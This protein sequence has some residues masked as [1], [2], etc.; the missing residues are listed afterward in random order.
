MFMTRSFYLQQLLKLALLFVFVVIIVDGKPEQ[1]VFMTSVEIGGDAELHDLASDPFDE[2]SF[3]PAVLSYVDSP[4]C[5]PT[6]SEF[7]ISN[8]FDYDVQ[9]Y[10]V[11]S[12]NTQFHPVM[13]QPQVLPSHHSLSVQLLFLP[14]FVEQSN[15]TLTFSSSVGD[16]QYTVRGSAVKN[17]YLIHPFVGHRL[18]AGVVYEQ[19]IVIYN[20][21]A[22]VLHIR[23]V[24]TTE[25]FM[26]LRGA[27]M[28]GG[29]G[30]DGDDAQFEEQ[31]S[32]GSDSSSAQ[33]AKMWEIEPFTSK[34]VIR[35][36]IS[37]RTTGDYQGYVHVKTNK[38][39]MVIPVELLVIEGGLS[40]IPEIIDFGVIPTPDLSR[41][42]DIYIVN[43]GS[44][45]V[46]IMDVVPVEPDPLLTI[47][48]TGEG[49]PLLVAGEKTLAFRV[50]LQGHTAGLVD[51]TLLVMTNHPNPA[52]ATIETPYRGSIMHGGLGFDNELSYF[53]LPVNN[54]SSVDPLLKNAGEAHLR[55][56]PLTN[57]FNSDISI[58]AVSA[59]S[60]KDMIAVSVDS[61][62][63]E[64]VALDD[65]ADATSHP[66][67]LQFSATRNVIRSN[68]A[69]DEIR[70]VFDAENV[71]DTFLWN[72]GKNPL[73]TL[74]FQC[75][76]EI[77]TNISTH[78]IPL[79]IF[80]G[81]VEVTFYDAA[82]V[83]PANFTDQDINGA[84]PLFSTYKKPGS[85]S[86]KLRKT[87]HP[88][89][90]VG[91]RNSKSAADMGVAVE[92]EDAS[93]SDDGDLLE[94][95]SGAADIN[96]SSPLHNKNVLVADIGTISLHQPKPALLLLGNPHPFDMPVSLLYA[97]INVSLCFVASWKRGDDEEDSD[98]VWPSR[99]GI[100]DTALAAGRHSRSVG[101]INRDYAHY[102]VANTLGL[103]VPNIS[104]EDVPLYGN[105]IRYHKNARTAKKRWN[106]K[107]DHFMSPYTPSGEL[108]IEPMHTMLVAINFHGAYG[109]NGAS[110]AVADPGKA[111]LTRKMN[112]RAER[113]EAQAS[114]TRNQ[115]LK[116]REIMSPVLDFNLDFVQVKLST[117]YQLLDVRYRMQLVPG[118]LA[119]AVEPSNCTFVLGINDRMVMG[120]NTHFAG[121]VTIVSLAAYT[122]Y[123]YIRP[124]PSPL[125]VEEEAG[126]VVPGGGGSNDVGKK[127]GALYITPKFM[128]TGREHLVDSAGYSAPG[129]GVAMY[130]CLQYLIRSVLLKNAS[131]SS[132]LDDFERYSSPA[133]VEPPSLRR[134]LERMLMRTTYVESHFHNKQYVDAF[135][136]HIKLKN[137][138]LRTYPHGFTLPPAE[139]SLKTDSTHHRAIIPETTYFS[140]LT[141]VPDITQV[142]LPPILLEQ[143]AIF[144][145]RVHN[146]FS[147]PVAFS[148]AM[149][150]ARG[151]SYSYN[152]VFWQTLPIYNVISTTTHYVYSR[153]AIS[154]KPSNTVPPPTPKHNFTNHNPFA[155]TMI[156]YRRPSTRL[157]VS[158]DWATEDVSGVDPGVDER[159]KKTKNRGKAKRNSVPSVEPLSLITGVE[160]IVKNLNLLSLQ[161]KVQLLSTANDVPFI[162]H[163]SLGSGA[164]KS[165]QAA[166]SP[167]GYTALPGS[168]ILL[169]PFAFVPTR[170]KSNPADLV[171][172]VQEMSVYVTNNFTGIDRVDVRAE[173]GAARLGLSQMHVYKTVTAD[174]PLGQKGESATAPVR[175]PSTSAPA[176]KPSATALLASVRTLFGAAPSVVPDGSAPEALTRADLS[177]AKLNLKNMKHKRSV[178]ESSDSHNRGSSTA[179]V[180]SSLGGP[181]G[182]SS[183]S[184]DRAALPAVLINNKMYMLNQTMEYSLPM[185]VVN[186]SGDASSSFE[187]G[188]PSVPMPHPLRTRS[189]HSLNMGDY[190]EGSVEVVTVTEKGQ[191]IVLELVNYGRS[192]MRVGNIFVNG[193]P[194]CTLHA[195]GGASINGDDGVKLIVDDNAS[196][197]DRENAWIKTKSKKSA[198]KLAAKAEQSM[199][200]PSDDDEETF[201]A[202]DSDGGSKTFLWQVL[203]ALD[204]FTQYCMMVR[205]FF[206]SS[207]STTVSLVLNRRPVI[208][209]SRVVS[210]PDPSYRG[211]FALG[212]VE[213]EEV[214]S[215]RR[216]CAVDGHFAALTVAP[217]EAL[218]LTVSAMN[219]CQLM[220]EELHIAIKPVVSDYRMPPITADPVGAQANQQKSIA[221]FQKHVS[222][223]QQFVSEELLQQEFTFM[224]YLK[225]SQEL[226]TSC[227]AAQTMSYQGLFSTTT[228]PD[229]R[230][231]RGYRVEQKVAEPYTHIVGGRAVPVVGSGDRLRATM[232]ATLS[233][234]EYSTIVA[235]VLMCTFVFAAGSCT[236]FFWGVIVSSGS[237]NRDKFML[238]QRKYEQMLASGLFAASFKKTNKKNKRQ[239]AAQPAPPLVPPA[240]AKEAAKHTR[241]SA[242]VPLEDISF[243]NAGGAVRARLLDE[244]SL[245][246]ERTLRLAAERVAAEADSEASKLSAAEKNRTGSSVKKAS[247]SA[248]KQSMVTPVAAKSKGSVTGKGSNPATP[249][250][251]SSATPAVL[252][253]GKKGAAQTPSSTA[254]TPA[255]SGAKT[256][257]KTPSSAAA[258]TTSGSASK[259]AG[260]SSSSKIVSSPALTSATGAGSASKKLSGNGG[261]LPDVS[262]GGKAGK[263]TSSS[264]AS[265]EKT[266]TDT[267][268][269]SAS[270]SGTA[271]GASNSNLN[272][273][274]NKKLSKQKSKSGISAGEDSSAP[275]GMGKTASK[276]I[277]DAHRASAGESLSVSNTEP[278]QQTK[279]SL[280]TSSLFE[281]VPDTSS[282]L[283]SSSALFSAA[284][285]G[286]LPSSTGQEA[287]NYDGL[288]GSPGTDA[289]REMDSGAAGMGFG[290]YDSSLSSLAFGASAG[291]G[292]TEQSDANSR[293]QLA[294][295]LL[296]K[297]LSDQGTQNSGLG[298]LSKAIENLSNAGEDTYDVNTAKVPGVIALD[299]PLRQ[300]QQQKQQQ[301]QKQLKQLR[302]GDSVSSGL[303]GGGL[304]SSNVGGSGSSHPSP[305]LQ[306][307]PGAPSSDQLLSSSL[308]STPPPQSARLA[309]GEE[310]EAGLG[311]DFGR[312]VS[313]IVASTSGVWSSDGGIASLQQ[314]N[315]TLDS[316]FDSSLYNSL[317]TG[318]SPAQRVHEAPPGLEPAAGRSGGGPDAP[319]GFTP[320]GSRGIKLPKADFNMFDAD[321]S[322]SLLSLSANARVFVPGG[323]STGALGSGGVSSSP[324]V[325]HLAGIMASLNGGSGSNN[326]TFYQQGLGKDSTVGLGGSSS[327]SD[328]FGSSLGGGGSLGGLSTSDSLDANPYLSSS[329]LRQGLALPGG[330]PPLAGIVGGSASGSSLFPPSGS[331]AG[332]V[333]LLSG[334][335]NKGKVGAGAGTSDSL[336]SGHGESSGSNPG[337]N[338]NS[339]HDLDFLPNE[340]MRHSE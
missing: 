212:A 136:E 317:S 162:L 301:R 331:D 82:V 44:A 105:C 87:V 270:A 324:E 43:S 336:S 308:L 183:A 168:S 120:T 140:P 321:D 226:V 42:V 252:E 206:A 186:S 228:K 211:M 279:P 131:Y 11:V 111:A 289:A 264:L 145:L 225:R 205:T 202:D 227:L 230:Q 88:S 305:S 10:S 126:L 8:A 333:S 177:A 210:A 224:L 208:V 35:L 178:F 184:V 128:C 266:K 65:F 263:Q 220:Y 272:S 265:A 240:G 132:Y 58:E 258:V 300:L 90:D 275:P 274:T 257:A 189:L 307:A 238:L 57:F 242:P 299:G 253:S 67:G 50:V 261:A 64:P 38:N 144:Y 119:S 297:Q 56:F 267:K 198:A 187:G 71:L 250:S 39:D 118:Y 268:D 185:P 150:P 75:N 121:N 13:F 190:A 66:G 281:G 169:G 167:T 138:W 246:Y 244:A 30:A 154:N 216:V 78:K 330:L 107:D 309:A 160:F 1:D 99:S 316:T 134:A 320:P 125:N 235:N 47:S 152:S 93:P 48:P 335:N 6:V 295:S 5:I 192:S 86:K 254:S 116:S 80:D 14:Y 294:E 285:F 20:P 155:D 108:Y 172:Q 337:S 28:G 143:L 165:S 269:S 55:A 133:P 68:D 32:F 61:D 49:F 159:P 303:G 25:E 149:D 36:S 179:H 60:C 260:I 306:P 262:G 182:N 318:P 59:S 83:N 313:S 41:Y 81:A 276:D 114:W 29:G 194:F 325:S 7:V 127:F 122:N 323:P 290:A 249:A 203:L 251:E 204:K 161:Q 73:Y 312:M 334:A 298:S 151:S 37:S 283:F 156:Y 236:F 221:Q 338:S 243:E 286:F 191:M 40:L 171:H 4:V 176:A 15:A 21:F 130:D 293:P 106:F 112:R 123:F 26:S 97:N 329:S 3:Q 24:F 110:A 256:A 340:W 284:P 53:F 315:S 76:L 282:S 219:D 291:G 101:A 173:S 33:Q 129:S 19:P 232:K 12:D 233:F 181:A 207:A 247:E 100:V 158:E 163:P 214:D 98:G 94:D 79:Y 117:P 18:P 23:E 271:G 77:W 328:W 54:R 62:M 180:S 146:P 339:V 153:Q 280:P 147:V 142:Q 237:S 304:G 215:S 2:L 170:R 84:S 314:S 332:S 213:P 96:Y 241:S 278:A 234:L 288:F 200:L 302:G 85:S 248:S 69:W 164:G 103:R 109:L 17:D 45:D 63:T 175:P 89:G 239:Q 166:S 287:D 102:H 51:N 72:V 70:L 188:A 231:F 245:R 22:E 196:K 229:G 16:I 273:A 195:Q 46:E 223:Q 199:T 52:L 115:P 201:N 141:L 148:I 9:L 326:N 292:L 95:D 27:G 157:S 217:G 322:D 104:K 34:E 92:S 137:E 193:D 91:T 31:T 218:N 135:Q 319:P 296:S 255:A 327:D 311:Q 197:S 124:A 174:A 222:M 139:I 209:G 277:K 259:S 113:A 310:G 74:P